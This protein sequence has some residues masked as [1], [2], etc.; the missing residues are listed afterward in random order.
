MRTKTSLPNGVASQPAVN[1]PSDDLAHDDGDEILLRYLGAALAG[2]TVRA[3]AADLRHFL[4]SGGTIPAT[5]KLVATYLA[6]F[7][8]SHRSSTLSRR[9]VAIGHAHRLAGYPSPTDDP[10]VRGTMQ[11]IR[12]VVGS[13]V[14]Q[15]APLQK[16]EL[17]QMVKGLK[18]VRGLRDRALLLVGFASAL[19]REELVSLNVED[20]CFVEE[21]VLLTLR[22]S[23]TDPTGQG[24]EIA[25][26]RIR[27]RHDPVG[28]LLKWLE[29]AGIASGAIFR[30][31]SRADRVLA[32]RLTGQAVAMVVKCRSAEA[33]LDP[34]RLAGH[35]LRAGFVTNAARNGASSSSIRRQTGH[36]SDGMVQRY[37]RDTQAFA[38]NPNRYVWQTK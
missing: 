16:V 7:A 27:G 21:G 22:R 23:K 29:T 20:V 6:Q 32:H 1:P 33:G 30:R 10:L 26:P 31:I 17:L 36:K 12:R 18:G 34:T 13:A 28:A 38:D 4:A 2:N 11:G 5:P 24:R 19:R 8:L 14:S 15:V 9:V 35:S 25:I 3:Y 37:I